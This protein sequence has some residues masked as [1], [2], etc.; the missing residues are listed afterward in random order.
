MLENK[1]IVVTGAASGIGAETC[2]VLKQHGATVVGVD[3]NSASEAVDRF[4]KADL[5]DPASIDLAV[6][7]IGDNID[8]LCNIA[9]LPPTAS[10]ELVLK[11]N[12]LGLRRLTEKMI[13]NLNDGASIVNMAS[14]AGSGWAQSVESCLAFIKENNFDSVS[15]FCDKHSI[16]G[17]RS[18]FFSKEVLVIWTIM[19]RWTWRDRGIRMNC[20]SPGPVDTPILKDFLETLG[21]RAEKDMEI[22]DRPGSPQDIAPVVAFLCSDGS[23]WMRGA[24]LAVD[25]GMNQHILSEIH[26]LNL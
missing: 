8:A 4:V 22:M 23:D 18:Y 24:N 16:E 2:R 14:L 19:N 15:V 13:G 1:T 21:E 10:P 6:A 3:R 12:V 7:D 26:G 20:V 17:A 9:G 11:V 5:S 25:G